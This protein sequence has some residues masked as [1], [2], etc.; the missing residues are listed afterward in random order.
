MA[1]PALFGAALPF[2][3]NLLGSLFGGGE[4]GGQGRG[5]EE[6]R[7]Q[8][9][10]GMNEQRGLTGRAND[11]L[12]PFYQGG[13][14]ELPGYMQ[15][16]Q[17]MLDPNKM[18]GDWMSKYQESPWAKQ[19]LQKGQGAISNAASASGGLGGTN[20]G[21]NMVDYTQQVVNADQKN[22]LNN[23]MNTY[24][25]GLGHQ[26]G[27]VGMGGQ[28]GDRMGGNLMNLAQ[29]LGQGYGEMGRAGMGQEMAKG[30]ERNNLFSSLGGIAGNLF[31]GSGG[32]F[33]AGGRGSQQLSN[34]G[35]AGN[36]N[37]RRYG[38]S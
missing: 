14:G 11:Y 3:G 20:Y 8:M 36:M 17:R 2:A 31:G 22:Y 26:Q 24:D 16:Y 34:L 25:K 21:Q 7:R 27:M 28:M 23:L 32:L 29:M 15:N 30:Q 19:Q 37:T 5:F 9:E 35:R 18:I 4:G 13:K 1:L 38:V 12:N 10:A 6:M 33:G